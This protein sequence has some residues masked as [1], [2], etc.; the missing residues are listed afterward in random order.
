MGVEGK[1]VGDNEWGWGLDKG[2]IVG[3]GLKIRVGGRVYVE[4]VGVGRGD[5]GDIGRKG[6]EGRV[7]VVGLD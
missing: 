6:V 2:G 3:E 7:E 5:K 4:M 1:G